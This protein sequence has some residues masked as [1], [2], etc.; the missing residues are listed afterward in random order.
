MVCVCA[1]VRPSAKR[2]LHLASV[3]CL[4]AAK[5]RSEEALAVTTL[6]AERSPK[7]ALART[8][9]RRILI[10]VHGHRRRKKPA[11]PEAVGRRAPERDRGSR[12]ARPAYGS[13]LGVGLGSGQPPARESLGSLRNF[14][15]CTDPAFPACRVPGVAWHGKAKLLFAVFED[16]Q[17]NQSRLSC[18]TYGVGEFLVRKCSIDTS[19]AVQ[20]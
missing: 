17:H 20:L 3:Y 2:W 19:L 16:L 5:M 10:W 15:A 12:V 18:N 7:L 9:T 4:C 8:M 11:P 14:E 13:R 6:S 1:H